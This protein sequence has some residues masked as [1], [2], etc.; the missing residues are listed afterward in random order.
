[1]GRFIRGRME[2][3]FV[4]YIGGWDIFFVL[5]DGFRFN[6]VFC[7]FGGGFIFIIIVNDVFI[8]CFIVSLV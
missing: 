6:V 4:V 7:I 2:G 1:M 3:M 5:Y 8:I